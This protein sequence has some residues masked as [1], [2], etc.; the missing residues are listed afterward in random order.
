MATLNEKQT[1][2]E[3]DFYDALRWLFVGA[4]TWVASN[5][6]SGNKDALAML[7]SLTQARALYEFFY[8]GGKGDDA[9][10]ADFCTV[11]SWSPT[12]SSIYNEYMGQGRP[13]NKRVSHL[14]YNRSLH[15]GGLAYDEST[16][17]KNQVL[18]FAKDLR[19]ITEQFISCAEP[20]F[21]SS[22]RSALDKALAEA[23]KAASI[24][25]I[26]NPL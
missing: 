6:S 16:H 13:A 9:R 19:N 26:A 7:A 25:S 21:R 2:L 3:D 23:G 10:A 24:R 14:V 12:T 11:G 8:A 22:A 4:V 1:F 17:L 18:N 5:D 15:A 20:Q